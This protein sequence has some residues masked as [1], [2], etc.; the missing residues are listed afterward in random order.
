MS[1]R[2]KEINNKREKNKK[3]GRE[4]NRREREMGNWELKRKYVIERVMR[5]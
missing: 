2:E 4:K 5:N 3:N 1:S